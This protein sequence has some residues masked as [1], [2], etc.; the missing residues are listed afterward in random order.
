[1]C[2]RFTLVVS[3][4][5]LK[6]YIAAQYDIFDVEESLFSPR[7]NIAPS[8][9]V[10]TIINDG[11][12]YRLGTLKWGLVPPFATDE[13]IGY[14]LI[15]A[16][17]ETIINKPSFRTSFEKRRCLILAD[18]FYEWE[19]TDQGKLPHR[20]VMQNQT[21][22][23]MAGV[24]SA[25]T[26]SDG[27]KLYTCAI[28]TT[29][30]NSIM[31]PYHDRMPVIIDEAEQKAWLTPTAETAQLVALMKPYDPSKMKQYRVATA[32]NNPFLDA[33][34]LADPLKE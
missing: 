27:T 15:N 33:P 16:K 23:A 32:V 20:F 22:F 19:K 21:V 8:Q 17:A 18:G 11:K 3:F 24:W 6:R 25:Y 12:K 7:Y 5:D 13:K 10:V 26:K 9:Q 34:H 30:A 4:E 1:M 31:A 14:A 29:R 2:G 28:I